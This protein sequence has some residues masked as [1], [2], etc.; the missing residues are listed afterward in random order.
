MLWQ[1][2]PA[3]SSCTAA[4]F[5]DSSPSLA[6][7]FYG[8]AEDASLPITP[9]SLLSDDSVD[10][11]LREMLSEAVF[12]ADYMSSMPK[13]FLMLHDMHRLRA[14]SLS[15]LRVWRLPASLLIGPSGIVGGVPVVAS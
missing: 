15:F 2:A 9:Y 13:F 1:A 4:D 6:G 8:D 11:S 7:G 14:L 10:A 3:N 5:S 12:R